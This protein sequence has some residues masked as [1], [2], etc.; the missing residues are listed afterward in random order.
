MIFFRR[1]NLLV[2]RILGQMPNIKT[3]TSRIFLLISPITVSTECKILWR[4][5][6]VKAAIDNSVP[7]S[8]ITNALDSVSNDSGWSFS[9]LILSEVHF[10]MCLLLP[11][12]PIQLLSIPLDHSRFIL[13][14]RI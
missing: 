8:R 3:D 11:S 10:S 2:A 6:I 13:I 9:I 7:E 14:I 4:I 5:S 1:L 12:C